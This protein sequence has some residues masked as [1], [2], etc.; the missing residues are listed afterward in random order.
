MYIETTVICNIYAKYPYKCQHCLTQ[1]ATAKL[2][3]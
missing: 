3:G 1:T 2:P